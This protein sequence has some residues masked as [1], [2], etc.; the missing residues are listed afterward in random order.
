MFDYCQKSVREHDYDRYLLSLFA[1]ASA[2]LYLWALFAF[3]FEIAKTREVVSDTT[4][5]LIRLQWWRDAIA[6]IYEGRDVRRHE[7]VEPL[8]AAIQ[9]FDLP[10]EE[11]DNLIYAREFDL[12]GVAPANMEGLINYCDYT[13]TP[14]T[15]LALKIIGVDEDKG[16]I[17]AVSVH[18]ALVGT[19][20]AVP[21]MLNDKPMMLPSDILAKNDMSEQKIFD[22]NEVKNLPQVI[23]EVLST[24]KEFRYDKTT[25]NSRFVKAMKAITESYQR[26]IES[27]QYDVL[28]SKLGM[29]PSFFALRIWAKTLF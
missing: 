25:I 22:F 4:I 29:R 3:N 27:A 20:R 8:A 24:Q 11:F 21:Y 16:V 12:E 23:S 6:E 18:Y 19:L 28:S 10:R 7:V 9:K 26:Q 17:K 2:R 5:G 1:P 15:R 14:L 13:A